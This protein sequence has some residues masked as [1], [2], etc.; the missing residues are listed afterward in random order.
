VATEQE[1]LEREI[2][3]TRQ[4]LGQDVDA[5]AEKVSPAQAARRGADRA[6]SALVSA[7]ESVMGSAH[8]AAATTRDR[9]ADLGDE[10]SDTAGQARD[11][12]EQAVQNAGRQVR[13]RTE[14]NPLAAGVIAFGIGW[15]VASL[16]PASPAEERLGETV[17]NLGE[18][19]LGPVKE[20]VT[21][22]A[23]E[24]AAEL[25][26]PAKEA[27]ASVRETATEAVA[28]VKDEGSSQAQD[29]TGQAR[30]AAEAVRDDATGDHPNGAERPSAQPAGEGRPMGH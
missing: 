14:G 18:E 10:V 28:T 30:S 1:Q 8:G 23:K 16:I 11:S 4:Q 21:A 27:A 15:L 13:R 24:A 17:R 22:A 6:K 12:A 2:Q 25:K 19:Q 26:E 3:R 29:L 5:L 9:A 7:K 20:Q